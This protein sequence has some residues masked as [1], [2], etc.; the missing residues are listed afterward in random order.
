MVLIALISFM[1]FWWWIDK[2]YRK[3]FNIVNKG[4][5]YEHVNRA[6]KIGELLLIILL[7]LISFLLIF[8]Y[9]TGM[10]P[11]YVFIISIFTLAFRAFMEWKNE[12]ETRRYIISILH[13]T[14]GL[15]LFCSLILF[16]LPKDVNYTTNAFMYSDDGIVAEP[17]EVQIIGHLKHKILYGDIFEG[18]LKL[19]SKVF[20]L[21]TFGLNKRITLFDIVQDRDR[22]YYMMEMNGNSRGEV[23]LSNDYHSFSGRIEWINLDTIGITSIKFAGPAETM[24]DAQGVTKEF[25]QE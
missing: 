22:F 17:V 8:I 23:W 14:M 21:T 2:I 3:K 19:D 10:E 13:S 25:L 18:Q 20:Y 16:S 24:E 15:I 1:V 6:H 9:P 7:L 4:I 12:K 5:Y 11:Y